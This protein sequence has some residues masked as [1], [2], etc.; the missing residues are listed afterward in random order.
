MAVDTFV[1]RSAVAL[2]LASTFWLAAPAAAA[3]HRARMGT[4]LEHQL[5]AGAQT[6]DVIVH[7]T[8][9]DVDQLA[10]RYNLSV[11]HLLKDGAVLRVTAGQLD[12]LS[13]DSAVDH[14]AARDARSLARL[15]LEARTLDEIRR[16]DRDTRERAQAIA[17]GVESE[18]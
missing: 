4:D 12:A 2:T 3:G 1:R 5:S 7:G 13:Q 10:R 9:A 15:L 6:I 8:A 18:I 11:K 16:V 14:L 17:R